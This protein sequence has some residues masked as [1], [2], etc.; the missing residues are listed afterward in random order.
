MKTG[1]YLAVTVLTV[2]L[3]VGCATPPQRTVLL[4]LQDAAITSGGERRDVTLHMVRRGDE[5]T[6][7]FAT[8]RRWNAASHAVAPSQLKWTRDPNEISGRAFVTLLPDAWVPRDHRPRGLNVLIDASADGNAIGGTYSGVFEGRE[9]EGKITGRIQPTDALPP[10]DKAGL[11]RVFL[12]DPN[13]NP[14]QTVLR[15]AEQDGG[16][17]WMRGASAKARNL[18]MDVDDDALD[19]T[20][21]LTYGGPDQTWGK[22]VDARFELFFIEGQIG[23]TVR[24]CKEKNWSDPWPVSGNLEMAADC[25]LTNRSEPIDPLADTRMLRI[26]EAMEDVKG[27]EKDFAAHVYSKDGVRQPYRLYTPDVADDRPVPLV[28]YLHG[29]GER[30]TDNRKQLNTWGKVF[31]RESVQKEHP[32]F[33]LVPHASNWYGGSPKGAPEGS[34]THA[35][36]ILDIVRQLRGRKEVDPSRIYVTGL[37]MGGYGTCELISRELN[38]FAAGVP[39]CGAIPDRANALATTPLWIFHGDSDVTVPV[40]HSRDLVKA[41]RARGAEPLYTEYHGVGHGSYKWTYTWPKMYDWMFA[42]SRPDAK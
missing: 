4:N 2:S 41:L 20:C 23:G 38:L 27:L 14:R 40:G 13:G 16:V 1:T 10:G 39:V 9:I 15:F 7:A 6:A 19:G 42:Q 29:A 17:A 26:S 12:P 35:E 8:A 31:A 18:E 37:S 32:C 5:W 24:L 25:H 11:L 34:P 33:V 3:L 22:P 36:L 30:G 21:E 28:V